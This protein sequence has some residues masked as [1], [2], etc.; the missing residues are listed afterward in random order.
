MG[1]FLLSA[2]VLMVYVYVLL[3]IARTPKGEIRNGP[4]ILWVLIVLG[5]GF[6][7]LAA[8]FMWGRPR[9]GAPPAGGSGGGGG[10]TR[11]PA[12]GPGPRPPA[13]LAPDDDPNF[14]KWLDEQAWAAKIERLRQQRQLPP[15]GPDAA[16]PKDPTT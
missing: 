3:D 2:I 4:R 15:D 12:G 6:L 7:G 14:I 9:V 10:G 13:P 8:W 16:K 5:M 1:R 11:R